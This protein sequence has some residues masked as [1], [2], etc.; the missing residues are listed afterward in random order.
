[1]P[2]KHLSPHHLPLNNQNPNNFTSLVFFII[3][4]SPSLFQ[5]FFISELYNFTSLLISIPASLM[6]ASTHPKLTH[7]AKSN[8]GKMQ[9][10]LL[11]P[12]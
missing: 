1:M 2:D 7:T 12:V 4:F 10:W 8:F 5:I 11:L 6:T 3:P 9:I